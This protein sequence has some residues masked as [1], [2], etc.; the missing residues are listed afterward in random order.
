M[1]NNLSFFGT[2][3]TPLEVLTTLMNDVANIKTIMVV[4]TSE[5]GSRL[6]CSDMEIG[7]A[8]FASELI[9]MHAREYM[10]E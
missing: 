1:V 9:R 10:E 3:I 5:T 6:R 8:L 7:T 4:V 2:M